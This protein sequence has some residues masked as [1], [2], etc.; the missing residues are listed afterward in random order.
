MDAEAEPVQLVSMVYQ[1][2]KELPPLLNAS[3]KTH[4]D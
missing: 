3:I 2:E 4:S 1:R